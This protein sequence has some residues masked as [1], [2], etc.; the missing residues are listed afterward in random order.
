M[1][2]TKTEPGPFDA[3]EK[4]RDDEPLFTLLG[5]D[6]DAPATI[7]HWVDLRRTRARKLWQ[8]DP[9][10]GRAE[11]IQC[12]E[13]EMVAWSM[14]DWRKGEPEQ[15]AR[16]PQR[17]TYAGGTVSAAELDEAGRKGKIAEAVRH[18]REAA[19]HASE[20]RD[21]LA[22]LDVLEDHE[23]QAIEVAI[24]RLDFVAEAHTPKRHGIQPSLPMEA[25]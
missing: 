18:L 3:L 10:A 8:D 23:R 6:P 14:D 9:E 13:A 20:A 4:A 2:S 7:H 15:F 17:A 16:V 25:A 12:S 22:A 24:S 19:F 1:G 11:L 21:K 5:R